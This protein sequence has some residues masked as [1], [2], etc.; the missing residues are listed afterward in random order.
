[1]S[2]IARVITAFLLLLGTATSLPAQNWP[3]RTVRIVVPFGPGSTPD[4]VARLVADGLQQRY[5]ASA[6]IVELQRLRLMARPSES[7]SEARWPSTLC[8]L[9]DYPTT[10]TRTFRR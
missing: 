8:C 2:A 6:F 7:A 10:L 9:Q 5:P 4:I 3:T 1:M